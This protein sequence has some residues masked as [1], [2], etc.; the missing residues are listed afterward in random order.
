MNNDSNDYWIHG[1]ETCLQMNANKM[2]CGYMDFDSRHSVTYVMCSRGTGTSFSPGGLAGVNVHLLRRSYE[3]DDSLHCSL[4]TYRLANR[5]RTLTLLWLEGDFLYS[6]DWHFSCASRPTKSSANPCTFI[7]DI[8][9]PPALHGVS[10]NK[11]LAQ[12]MS[13]FTT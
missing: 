6:F 4:L 7:D 5:D 10:A 11:M 13:A 2:Y 9:I 1:V 12:Q 3:F 8:I